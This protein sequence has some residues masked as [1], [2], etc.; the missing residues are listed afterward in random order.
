MTN[1]PETTASATLARK[2]EPFAA[3]MSPY[4]LTTREPVATIALQVA[5][6]ATTLLLAPSGLPSERSV[7]IEVTRSPVYRAYM[8]SWEWAMPLFKEG[9][10]G[11]VFRNADPVDDVRD[12][13][14]TLHED[15]VFAPL[16]PYL[17][18]ELFADD[19]AYLRAASA[20]VLKS[21]P[22]PGVSIPIAAG[23]DRFAA[24]FGLVV[25]RSTPA[26][27][28]Q[29]HES[30]MGRVIFRTTIPALVQ[31]SAD[32]LLLTRA[33]LSDEREALARAISLAFET[34]DPSAVRRAAAAYA[35]AFER[36]RG[37]LTAPPGRGEE[38]EVRVVVGEASLVGVEF[39]VDAAL[40][41][42]VGAATGRVPPAEAGDA[43][44]RSLVIRSVG[45]R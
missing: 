19:T 31:G 4:H 32:R 38:D 15:P 24:E 3:V 30:R 17:R 16:M 25:V 27:L 21:G 13:C 8:E 40:R 9:V 29:K 34:R 2:A 39:P 12:A 22:D 11:S 6:T 14:R 41:A 43:V 1:A 7:R 44:A 35:D 45:G 20:D 18:E 26:S 28:V 36:E 5:Q 37:D 33:L 42:S 10:V 23:L